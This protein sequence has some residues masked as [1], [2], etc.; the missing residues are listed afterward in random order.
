MSD[1]G[2]AAAH[3]GV[4]AVM[5]SKR[6][7]AIVVGRG[8]AAAPIADRVRFTGRMPRAAALSLLSRCDAIYLG[9][10]PHRLYERYGTSL[11]KLYDGMLCGRPILANY[12]S[13]NDPIAEAA[14][15][16]VTPA[17]DVEAIASAI[18]TLVGMPQSER[19]AMGE[20]GRSFVRSHHD[21]R[22][23][24]DRMLASIAS[25]KGRTGS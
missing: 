3:N 23:L 4:G 2:H 9:L 20:R 5:G 8:K 12:T 18:C 7:K 10:H 17:G 25:A 11:N 24:A 16:I 19:D 21:H 6:L 1:R 15:G 14:C 22:V 13:A